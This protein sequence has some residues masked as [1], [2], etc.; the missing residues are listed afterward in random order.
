MASKSMFEEDAEKRAKKAITQWEEE[1]KLKRHRRTKKEVKEAKALEEKA[2]KEKAKAR[3]ERVE[4]AGP[5]QDGDPRTCP[6]V[7]DVM[8]GYCGKTVQNKS[9]KNHVKTNKKCL[10]V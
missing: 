5:R 6:Y 9:I 1:V 7:E 3:E 8:C 4:K 10:K 2:R